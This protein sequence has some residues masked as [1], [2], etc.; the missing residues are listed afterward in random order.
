MRSA[1]RVNFGRCDGERTI[2]R[3][4]EKLL[5]AAGILY[6]PTDYTWVVAKRAPPVVVIECDED[7]SSL[8][9]VLVQVHAVL[10][11]IGYT[12]RHFAISGSHI[13]I[14]GLTN[15]SE[16]GSGHQ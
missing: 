9:E 6:D 7:E 14:V 13:S 8:L 2:L 15:R 16:S 4:A 10:E 12:C 1:A 5:S 3:L 11:A